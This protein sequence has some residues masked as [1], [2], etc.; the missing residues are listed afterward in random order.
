MPNETAK[1]KYEVT[2]RVTGYFRT[3]VEADDEA[4]AHAIADG[5]CSDADFGPL[6]DVDWENG[7]I[8]PA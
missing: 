2:K 8:N 5:L 1:K 4:Q 6:E 7:S 3:V